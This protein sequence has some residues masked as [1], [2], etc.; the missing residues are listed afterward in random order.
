M[1]EEVLDIIDEQDQIVGQATYQEVHAQHLRHRVV[2]VNLLNDGDE[3]L[4]Q[5][6]SAH[7]NAYPLYWGFAAGG[8]V[9]HGETYERALVREAKEELGVTFSPKD[10]VYKGE[11]N[12]VD[13]RGHQIHYKTYEVHYDGPIESQNEEVDA[14]QFV[15][16]GTLKEMIEEGKEKMQPE[17]IEV[18]KRHHAKELGY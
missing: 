12:Y 16:W 2:H 11:G 9:R 10:F 15:S 13:Q 14:V 7:K 1:S 6:R 8:H 4:L 18:L 3:V 17:F 5:L